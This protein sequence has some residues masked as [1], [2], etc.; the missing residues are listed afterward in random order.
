MKYS[1]SILA[2]IIM[3]AFAADLI[4][5]KIVI[6]LADSLFNCDWSDK[7]WQV[8]I[9]LNIIPMLFNLNIK[10]GKND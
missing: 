10:I 6:W 3:L 8:F 9:A 2:I 7:F 5:V 4:M 1:C